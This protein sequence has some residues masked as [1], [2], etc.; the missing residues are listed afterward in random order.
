[1][2]NLVE[3]MIPA[4][5]LLQAGIFIQTWAH[6]ELCIWQI[7]RAVKTNTPNPL[8]ATIEDF[9][10]RSRTRDLVKMFRQTKEK[11]P[12]Q[13][14]IEVELLSNR[15]NSGLENRNL[16]A[17]GAAHFDEATQ[18]LLFAHY[19]F[20]KEDGTEKLF[21]INAPVRTQQIRTEIANAN[22]LLLDLI[23]LRKRIGAFL[24]TSHS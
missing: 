11:L 21:T 16:A 14:C 20:K 19:F 24:E 22:Q 7:G 8:M 6:I 17:H 1:M 10:K 5:V 23:D 18:G 15:I 2:R 4:E 13:L 9:K 12:P 3:K